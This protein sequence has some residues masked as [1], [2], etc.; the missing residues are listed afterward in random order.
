MTQ[1]QTI[2]EATA[3]GEEVNMVVLALE[4]V[5]V[6]A[7]RGVGIIALLSLTLMLMNPDITPEQL[8]QG[9]RDTSQFICLILEGT[10]VDSEAPVVMN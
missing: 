3:T 2:V 1:G 6:G 10:G 5:L 8:Q 4:D 9:V 7:P